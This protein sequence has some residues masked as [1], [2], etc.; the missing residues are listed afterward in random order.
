MQLSPEGMNGGPTDPA[1]RYDYFVLQTRS[2]RAGVSG[3]LEN[4]TTGEKR[5]FESSEELTA[6]V[7]CWAENERT[8][9]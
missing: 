5:R 8:A 9:S 7:R 1:A 4:L 2:D 3:V 6:F